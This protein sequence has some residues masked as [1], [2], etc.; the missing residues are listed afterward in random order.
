M[1]KEIIC[2]FCGDENVLNNQPNE[3]YGKYF[4]GNKTRDCFL[5]WTVQDS[6]Q[7][8]KNKIIGIIIEYFKKEPESDEF[9]RID[10]WQNNLIIEIKGVHL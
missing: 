2:E 4:C 9:I 10:E 3:F 6:I 8:I 5:N 1:D 7:K